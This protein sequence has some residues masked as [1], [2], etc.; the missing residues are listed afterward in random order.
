MQAPSVAASAA[1]SEVHFLAWQL[2]P[3]SV[4]ADADTSA[5]DIA[6]GVDADAV[7]AAVVAAASSSNDEAIQGVAV[8]EIAGAI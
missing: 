1:S 2:V 4:A 8:A 6:S 5:G 7:D 3:Q